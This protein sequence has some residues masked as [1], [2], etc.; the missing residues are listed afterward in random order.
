MFEQSFVGG[1]NTTRKASSVLVSFLAQCSL[2]AV[3]VVIPLIYT[4]TLPKTQLTSFLVAPPPPTTTT[5]GGY[6]ATESC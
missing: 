1:E 5:S 2:I 4:E 3:A 6:S